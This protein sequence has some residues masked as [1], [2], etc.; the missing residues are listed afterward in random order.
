MKQG[1]VLCGMTKVMSKYSTP[2]RKHR[3]KQTNGTQDRWCSMDDDDV[4]QR[5]LGTGTANLD[6]SY[7]L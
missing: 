6:Y 1:V 2:K 7:G 5:N 3:K 4:K